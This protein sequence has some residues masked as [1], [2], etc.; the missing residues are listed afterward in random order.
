MPPHKGLLHQHS[1]RIGCLSVFYSSC[2]GHSVSDSPCSSVATLVCVSLTWRENAVE[3][4]RGREKQDRLCGHRQPFP[5]SATL[6]QHQLN[7]FFFLQEGSQTQDS[8]HLLF[9]F[10]EGAI[11]VQVLHTLSMRELVPLVCISL[12][13]CYFSHQGVGQIVVYRGDILCGWKVEQQDPVAGNT[14]LKHFEM[15]FRC[16]ALS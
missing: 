15:S 1:E 11:V 14:S 5:T 9:L 16:A 7:L 3:G 6:P 8:N 2:H 10:R 4:S 12:L 13:M